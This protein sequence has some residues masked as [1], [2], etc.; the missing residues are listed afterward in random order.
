MAQIG[1]KAGEGVRAFHIYSDAGRSVMRARDVHLHHAQLGWVESQGHMA[2][3]IRSGSQGHRMTQLG[4]GRGGGCA[5]RRACLSVRLRRVGRRLTVG[6]NTLG[7]LDRGRRALIA[8]W[9]DSILQ[10][11]G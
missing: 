4:H 6:R 8:G 11:R 5:G 2:D 10:G 1:L 7:Q 3:P 9:I